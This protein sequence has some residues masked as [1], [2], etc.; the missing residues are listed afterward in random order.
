MLHQ[1][2]TSRRQ[3]VLEN[4]LCF[5]FITKSSGVD[6]II[7]HSNDSF[8]FVYY[9]PSFISVLFVPLTSLWTK[10]QS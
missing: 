2:R 8:L 4:V 9:N 7:L 10:P 1:D 3:N 6:V 5:Y